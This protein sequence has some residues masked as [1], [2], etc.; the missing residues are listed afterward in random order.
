M[1]GKGSNSFK[2]EEEQVVASVADNDLREAPIMGKSTGWQK[3]IGEQTITT[4]RS[5]RGKW[6]GDGFA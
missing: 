3:Y 4:N 5:I 2:G 1:E 6:S